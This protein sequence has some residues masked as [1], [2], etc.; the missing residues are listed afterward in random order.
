MKWT[1]R[2][3][4]KWRDPYP[5]KHSWKITWEITRYTRIY[6]EDT[7]HFVRI[8]WVFV[9][10]RFQYIWVGFV[11]SPKLSKSHSVQGF[12]DLLVFVHTY[13]LDN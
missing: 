10:L 2:E 1:N 4:S 13:A 6:A 12:G 3:I 8:G 11:K 9:G 7:I 5:A